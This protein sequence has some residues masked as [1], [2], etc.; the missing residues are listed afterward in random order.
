[1]THTVRLHFSY[2]LK[3]RI[4]AKKGIN[5]ENLENPFVDPILY[6]YYTETQFMIIFLHILAVTYKKMLVFQP[7]AFEI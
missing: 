5:L 6:R 2:P 3:I 1:M 7:F 4:F